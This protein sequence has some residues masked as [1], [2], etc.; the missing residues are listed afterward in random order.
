ML[1]VVQSGRPTTLHMLLTPLSLAFL[2]G[3]RLY[4]GLA[5]QEVNDDATSPLQPQL[6]GPFYP[7][8]LCCRHNAV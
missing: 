4:K 5:R 2:G 7:H 3:P 6:A 1:A 8:A